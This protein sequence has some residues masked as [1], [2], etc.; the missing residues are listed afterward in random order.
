MITLTVNG[1]ARTLPEPT[2]LGR[3]L[4]EHGVDSQFVAVAYN[5]T[6]LRRQEFGQIT[7]SEGDVVEVVRPVGG[8]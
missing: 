8:G 7:L 1:E 3:F 4:N 2:P 5:G 6:V